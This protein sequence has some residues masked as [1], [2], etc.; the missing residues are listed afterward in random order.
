M[1]KRL[2][3]VSS[4]YSGAVVE[5]Q[6]YELLEYYKRQEWFEDVLLVQSYINEEDKLKSEIILNKFSFRTKFFWMN[7]FYPFYYKRSVENLRAVIEGEVLDNTV[8]HV[9]AGIYGRY[10]RAALSVGY[11]KLM[12]L[13]EFRGFMTDEITYTQKHGIIEKIK[14]II[15]KGHIKYCNKIMQSDE[16]MMYSAVSPLLREIESKE[17]GFDNNRISTHPNLAASYFTFDKE[18]RDNVRKQLGISD[19]QIVIV[20]SSGESGLW[21]KDIGIID[22]LISKGYVVLNLSQ[23]EVKKPNVITRFIPHDEM[24]AY[25]SAGDAALLWREDVPLNNAACPSKF[26]EFAVMGL[27]VIHNKTVDIVTRFTS[28]NNSGV[29]IDSSEEINLGKDLFSDDARAKRCEAGRSVFS[30]EEI[31]K[32]YYSILQG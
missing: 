30:V 6:V 25:L 17:E 14:S 29:G 16:R 10:V 27:F 22:T 3:Y 4:P 32:D 21:Q 12:I 1:S 8:F 9:R 13:V 19:D 24:P 23:T 5:G 20:T 26:C 31:A 15:K 11:Q 7:P 18:Q 2:I 28:E